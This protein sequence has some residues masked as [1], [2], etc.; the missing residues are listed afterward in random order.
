MMRRLK[1]KILV[2]FIVGAIS[3]F[4]FLPIG[5]AVDC[6]KCDEYERWW[7]ANAGHCGYHGNRLPSICNA[8]PECLRWNRECNENKR[9]RAECWAN[10]GK[11]G[12]IKYENR[13]GQGILT[14]EINGALMY[15]RGNPKRQ[16]AIPT[17]ITLYGDAV[18]VFRW[19]KAVDSLR[20]NPGNRGGHHFLWMQNG[21]LK[22]KQGSAPFLCQ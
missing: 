19:D 16:T 20:D 17:K 11:S 12:C 15:P 8:D 14:I 6:S 7:Q 18:N 13:S 5:Y 1:V 9:L 22:S 21:K 2:V 10:C 3:P 4:L